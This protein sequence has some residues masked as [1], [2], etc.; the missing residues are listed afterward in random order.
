MAVAVSVVVLVVFQF[1]LYVSILIP[2]VFRVHKYNN[3]N[4]TNVM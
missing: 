3:V 4:N 2:I 1:D